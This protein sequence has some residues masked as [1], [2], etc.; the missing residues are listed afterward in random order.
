MNI[1]STPDNSNLQRKLK[2]LRVIE[3]KKKNI[4]NALKGNEN[5]FEL[6]GGLS[7]QGFELS[8][9]DCSYKSYMNLF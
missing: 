4:E 8:G 9:F 6:A 5:W 7:Y 2:K 1:Q 3:G